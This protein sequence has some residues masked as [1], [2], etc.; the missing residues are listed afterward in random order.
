MSGANFIGDEA[1]ASLCF[2]SV[3]ASYVGVNTNANDIPSIIANSEYEYNGNKYAN[4]E[5]ELNGDTATIATLQEFNPNVVSAGETLN[6][7]PNAT[8]VRYGV[9]N[10]SD[11]AGTNVRLP[12]QNIAE[13]TIG[14]VWI[15]NRSPTQAI[16]LQLY[17]QAGATSAVT[18]FRQLAPPHTRSA[19]ITLNAGSTICLHTFRAEGAPNDL[20]YNFIIFA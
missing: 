19:T 2:E 15:Q 1:K 5:K 7:L 13:R 4:L 10:P 17:D 18:N 14:D 11:F 16:T 6:I 12:Y 8:S 3:R 20:D 9:N